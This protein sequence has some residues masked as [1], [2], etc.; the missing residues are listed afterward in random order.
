MNAENNKEK[1][2]LTTHFN[3]VLTVEES[4]RG[5]A[6]LGKQVYLASKIKYLGDK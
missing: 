3:K 2:K 1:E 5:R 4:K 6:Q